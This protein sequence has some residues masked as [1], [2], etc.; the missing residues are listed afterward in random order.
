M[1]VETD[2]KKQIANL[3]GKTQR[4]I[5]ELMH[6]WSESGAADSFTEV[7]H[8]NIVAALDYAEKHGM[9]LTDTIDEDLGCYKR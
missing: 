8:L 9:S 7:D 3:K 5:S 4:E 6:K 1:S 2:I